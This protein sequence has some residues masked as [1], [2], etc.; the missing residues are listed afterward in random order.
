MSNEQSIRDAAAEWITGLISG[1]GFGD[2]Y[3]D[4]EVK[5]WS[6]D[7]LSSD[8]VRRIRREAGKRS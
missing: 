2:D 4:D 5:Q 3:V 8:L 7:L 6:G 1:N